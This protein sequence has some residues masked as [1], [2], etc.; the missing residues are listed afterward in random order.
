MNQN[1][2][3]SLLG[4]KPGGGNP[5]KLF[6][7]VEGI[8]SRELQVAIRRMPYKQFLE[9]AYWFA[10]STVVKSRVG[11][12]CQVYNS[13]VRISVHHRTYDTHGREHIT[14]IDLIVLCEMCHG[15]FHGHQTIDF[16]PERV[17]PHKNPNQVQYPIP[18]VDIPNEDP[19]L[20]TDDLVAKCRTD[21]NG[22]TSATMQAFGMKRPLRAGWAKRLAGTSISRDDYKKAVE[23]R[24]IYGTRLF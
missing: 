11:M 15:L 4:P 5:F 16:I 24:Y 19:I 7:S 3:L 6:S 9:T 20:L 1:R 2:I 18:P 10:V 8:E 22:F 13:P 21:R 14:Q 17:R 23:G 12:R